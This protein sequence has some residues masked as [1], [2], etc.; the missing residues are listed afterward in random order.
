MLSKL[1]F[2]EVCSGV[3]LLGMEAML[4][5]GVFKENFIELMVT[6]DVSNGWMGETHTSKV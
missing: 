1:A 2:H 6:I 5:P 3:S 4:R